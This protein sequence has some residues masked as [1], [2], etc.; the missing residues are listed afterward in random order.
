M[1]AH[2]ESGSATG[3]SQLTREFFS[4]STAVA[5]V[6][7]T[8]GTVY[9]FKDLLCYDLALKMTLNWIAPHFA[10]GCLCE[11]LQPRVDKCYINEVII[12]VI[13]IIINPFSSLYGHSLRF[14]VQFYCHSPIHTQINSITHLWA[15][16]LSTRGNTSFSILLK[17]TS[18][19]QMGKTGI[20][21]TTFCLGDDH[22]FLVTQGF[23]L[24]CPLFHSVY[25]L[26]QRKTVVWCPLWS[27]MSF[28]T[29]DLISHADT[30]MSW[31]T[32]GL[33]ETIDLH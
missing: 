8:V 5:K 26:I 10:M 19:M 14:T 6:L 4:L 13:F 32:D 18:G 20:K 15:A 2:T 27:W 9:I 33:I 23:S 24:K 17:D 22:F 31:M 11:A 3:F 30:V 29:F 28:V 16:V 7:I 25:V 1:A 12:I 21:P